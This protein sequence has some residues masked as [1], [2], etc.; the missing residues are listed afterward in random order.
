MSISVIGV[1]RKAHPECVGSATRLDERN[2]RPRRVYDPGVLRRLRIENL[3]LIREAE[4][5]LA[6]GLVALTGETGAGKTIVTQAIGLLLG[7]KAEA[8]AVGAASAEAYVEAELDVPEGFFDEE[9][10]E[11][12]RDLRP[13]D[14]TGLVVARRVTA[15]GRSRAYA[16]GRSVARDDVVAATERLLALSG[17]FAQ[18]RLTR[19]AY[20][21]DLLDAYLGPEQRVRRAEARDAWRALGAATRRVEE[22]E[23][24]AD[25]E[26]DRLAEL[27]ALVEDTEGLEPDEEERLRAERERIRHVADLGE[28]AA[29]AAAAIEPDDGDGARALAAAAERALA[30]LERMAPEL[31]SAA[32]ELRELV[33]RLTEVASDVRRFAETLDGDP[34][35]AA[36]VEERL[37]RIADVRRR[38]RAAS[39][40][41]LLERRA[42]ALV[43]LE[44]AGAD[45]DPLERARA[46]G[47]AASARF[48]AAAAT[49]AAA[50]RT[51]AP[52]FAADVAAELADLGMG[53]GEFHVE[54]RERDPGPAGMDEA[55]FLVRPNAGLPLA[56]V[57]DTASG[58]ELSR[59]AVALSAVAG[60]ETLVLDEIDAGVGGETAHRVAAVLQR[61]AERAQVLTITH[62]PQIASVA[63]QH[64]RVEK[65]PGDPTHTRIAVLDDAE[66]RD[67]LERM[68]GGGEFVSA[69]TADER[70]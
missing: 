42:A 4:L 40:E 31:E 13:E 20:Q 3:V 17:Q 39:Y 21:L 43:E 15:D 28:G 60:G 23:R 69:V 63:D 10:L 57:A 22:L 47:A 36:A 2:R 46:D 53:E 35:R 1:E 27:E 8:G 37:D 34:A 50:R 68:L 33:V 32:G 49:L 7:A 61:L 66:R 25:T 51:A 38:H 62:L 55:V 11:A 64:L 30:P 14:E 19:T 41:E 45:G 24:G 48:D 54:L 29:A 9:G 26:R 18:R 12:L 16:W 56:P 67:E 6:P 58:G 44:R 65:V 59:I 70:P 52:A 5:A